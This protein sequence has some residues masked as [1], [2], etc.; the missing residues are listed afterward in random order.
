MQITHENSDA[1]TAVVTVKIE[2][3]DYA[4]KVDSSLRDVR[5]KVQMPGFRRGNVP[6][7]MVRKMY[8]KSVLAEEVDKLLSESLNQYLK[9]N[10]VR[11]MGQPMPL[12]DGANFDP[13]AA[14]DFKFTFE[15]GLEP[16]FELELGHH[17]TLPY[18]KIR[19]EDKQVDEVIERQ[20]NRFGQFKDAAVVEGEEVLKGSFWQIDANGLP[21]H[22]G[23]RVEQT[24]LSLK[25]MTDE[26]TKDKFLGAT[27]G[28]ILDFNPLKAFGNEAD[29]A[30]MLNINKSDRPHLEADYQ[31]TIF[32]IQN[33]ELAAVDQELFDKVFGPGAIADLDQ[34]RAR[35]AEEVE[36]S[37]VNESMQRLSVDARR[38][39]SLLVGLLPKAFLAKWLTRRDSS[40]SAEQVE[41]DWD[42]ID[43]D[44]KWQ[45]IQGR[46]AEQKQIQVTRKEVEG[47][48]RASIVAQFRQYGMDN[49]PEH[50]L[51][52]LAQKELAK[53]GQME[54]LY[55]SIL[56]GK[57]LDAIHASVTLQEHV[58]TF[59]ELKALYDAE[60]ADKA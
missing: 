2:K 25:F 14:E 4:G 27:V 56:N 5:R 8:G 50:L 36:K 15:L 21:M 16:E 60:Q 18:Y 20:R 53:E 29:V 48:A 40:I 38:Q 58:V 33:F 39:L 13:E 46:I 28:D 47:Q 1:Q 57:V 49:I 24:S 59:D 42:D 3:N 55:S 41:A 43:R 10:K 34:F 45:L 54:N 51:E 26:A 6:I 31:F 37:S 7:G 9:D 17:I 11:Y 44:L 30:A 22:D 12:E 19:V 52:E 23:V 32:S 35:V